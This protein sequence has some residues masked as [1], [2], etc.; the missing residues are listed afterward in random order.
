MTPPEVR[1]DPPGGIVIDGQRYGRPVIVH[2]DG[3]DLN[4]PLRH[5]NRGL[6]GKIIQTWLERYAPEVLIIGLGAGGADLKLSRKAIARLEASAVEWHVLP[7]KHACE[8]YQQLYQSKRV[9]A[10]MHLKG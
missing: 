2:P 1:Y 3:V 6:T 10:A 8:Q 5:K 4:W 7:T 9:L